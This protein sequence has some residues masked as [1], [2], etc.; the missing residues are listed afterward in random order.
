MEQ[1]PYYS[2]P[3]AKPAGQ[4]EPPGSLLQFPS[5]A[6]YCNSILTVFNNLRLCLPLTSAN[7]FV[8][9]LQRCFVHVSEEISALSKYFFQN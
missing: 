5:L 4:N 1:A 3:S 9:T 2:H 8:E 7:F 6:L